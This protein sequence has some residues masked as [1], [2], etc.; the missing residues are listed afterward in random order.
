[1]AEKGTVS[2]S[3]SDLKNDGSDRVPEIDGF[4]LNYVGTMVEVSNSTEGFQAGITLSVK[5]MLISGI[6]ISRK[7]FILSHPTL[8]SVEAGYISA[9]KE[10][11]LPEFQPSRFFI[12]LRDAKIFAPGQPPIPSD[13]KGTFWRVRIESVDGFSL[14]TIVRTE[15]E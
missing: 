1:M 10:Q 13:G 7:D 8:E 14:G 12:H 4:L 15:S 5:G 11:N 9:L 6:L 3:M 2:L